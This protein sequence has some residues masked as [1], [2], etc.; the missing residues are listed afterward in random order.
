MRET[1]LRCQRA[2]SSSTLPCSRK[3]NGSRVEQH[4][5]DMSPFAPPM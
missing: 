1:L 3:K 4:G 2:H 5:K